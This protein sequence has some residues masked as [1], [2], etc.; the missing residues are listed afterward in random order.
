MT[1]TPDHWASEHASQ[2]ALATAGEL[3]RRPY[4]AVKWHFFER[5]IP[6]DLSG[7]RVLDF[8]CGL[9]G[10]SV[11][12]ASRGAVVTGIDQSATAIQTARYKAHKDGVGARC[13]FMVAEHIVGGPYDVI[14]SKDIL[15]HIPDD[16]AWAESVAAALK[17]D[18]QLIGSTQ[19]CWS[20]NFLLEVGYNRLWRGDT[21]WMG[22]DR[23]HLRFYSP[24]TLKRLMQRHGLIVQHWA[25]HWIIPSNIIMWVTFG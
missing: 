24:R 17:P 7:Q 6:S 10:M 19:N 8:G 16:D 11:L 23:T 4:N 2:S 12:C 25:S 13:R 1:Y 5:L 9:G 22:W 14:I 20:L 3:G 21:K 18:G 15:E